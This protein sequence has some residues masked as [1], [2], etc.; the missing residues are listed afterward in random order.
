MLTSI[1]NEEDFAAL[2]D[3]EGDEVDLLMQRSVRDA[4][5][6]HKQLGQSVVVWKD[7]QM[8]ILSPDE[9]DVP[10]EE[11]EVLERLPV[12]TTNGTTPH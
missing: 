3:S 8:R 6:R 9:I 7:G 12:A 2:I 5:R 10:D 4:L 11:A 1:K